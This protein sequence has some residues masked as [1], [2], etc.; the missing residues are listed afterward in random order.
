LINR[1][2]IG[3]AQPFSRGEEHGRN[4]ASAAFS[5]APGGFFG[6][7]NLPMCAVSLQSPMS[8]QLLRRFWA[9]WTPVRVRK[10]RQNKKPERP[11]IKGAELRAGPPKN[12]K[13]FDDRIESV[14]DAMKQTKYPAY[15]GGQLR[16]KSGSGRSHADANGQTDLI[17]VVKRLVIYLTER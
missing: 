6:P 3:F 9:K 17:V 4:C 8:Q 15:D 7:S 13:L 14:V 16:R 10:A 2:L 5:T 11:R 12:S 1:G